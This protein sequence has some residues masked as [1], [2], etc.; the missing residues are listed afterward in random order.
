MDEERLTALCPSNASSLWT[1]LKVS[2]SSNFEA[3]VSGSGSWRT[4]RTPWRTLLQT[5]QQRN[6][7]DQSKSEKS[8][9]EGFKEWESEVASTNLDLVSVVADCMYESH[10]ATGVS[11]GL[12]D[13]EHVVLSVPVFPFQHLVLCDACFFIL[14]SDGEQKH[15]SCNR[16]RNKAKKLT[17]KTK[18][19]MKDPRTTRS[20]ITNN[21]NTIQLNSNSNSNSIKIKQRRTREKRKRR[22][23]G[24][25]YLAHHVWIGF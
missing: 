3:R 2:L 7:T 13:K 23:K 15:H 5:I 6:K 14:V 21:L 4:Q 11:N 16:P 8:K 9:P 10:G 12:L 19:I 22:G 17:V 24:G 20:K 1:V 25:G 18:H